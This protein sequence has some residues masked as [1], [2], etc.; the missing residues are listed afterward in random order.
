MTGSSTSPKGSNNAQIASSRHLTSSAV[1]LLP[2][3]LGLATAAAAVA[4]AAEAATSIGVTAVLTGNDMT[5]NQ[6]QQHLYKPVSKNINS[7]NATT[8]PSISA[9]EIN[10]E[11]DSEEDDD[12]DEDDEM[13]E[14]DNTSTTVPSITLSTST[15]G[16][17]HLHQHQHQQQ[18]QQQLQTQIHQQ[19]AQQLLEPPI[20]QQ[21]LQLSDTSAHTTD[22][23]PPSASANANADVNTASTEA[24]ALILPD[25]A[26]LDTNE[27]N[28]DNTD[29][30]DTDNMN[31][32]PSIPDDGDIT[33]ELQALAEQQDDLP[34][35]KKVCP[36]G[37]E[38][39]DKE[40]LHTVL[41][42]LI[43][44]NP[45]LGEVT[46][47]GRI[48]F[49]KDQIVD[50][51]V[52]YSLFLSGRDDPGDHNKASL[53][54]TLSQ[55]FLQPSKGRVTM[56]EIPMLVSRKDAVVPSKKTGIIPRP[57]NRSSLFD[58][59][60]DGQYLPVNS[61]R[62]EGLPPLNPPVHQTPARNDRKSLS[63]GSSAAESPDM[64]GV[65]AGTASQKKRKERERDEA[66][67]A[68]DPVFKVVSIRC[69][70]L[71][72]LLTPTLGS[73]KTQAASTSAASSSSANTSSSAAA[74]L[75]LASATE[76]REM[77]VSSTASGGLEGSGS[78]AGLLSYL[79]DRDVMY[80]RE[81]EQAEERHREQ[82]REIEARHADELARTVEVFKRNEALQKASVTRL[83]RDLA[84]A[85][86][87]VGL[88]T[89]GVAP[90]QWIGVDGGEETV[91]GTTTSSA[92]G[93]PKIA[94]AIQPNT[95]NE[96][97]AFA[98]VI[99]ER[100]MAIRLVEDTKV[101]MEAA[102]SRV[103]DCVAARRKLEEVVRRLE[104]ERD[105]AVLAKEALR[106]CAARWQKEVKFLRGKIASSSG[107]SVVVAGRIGDGS[108][109]SGAGAG[110][111]SM[112]FEYHGK[113]TDD[114]SA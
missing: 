24:S 8:K 1:P 2:T 69:L 97:D 99:A 88:M 72:A 31:D 64:E 15:S 98:S 27:N 19:Q 35:A 7:I 70:L 58:I 49:T 48:S 42:T 94:W 81:R 56:K 47:D 101:A 40:K 38:D 84:E 66:S 23:L 21:Q 93:T 105:E 112:R 12:E 28:N 3:G 4:A 110:G 9:T 76:S 32:D 86:A 111:S 67:S 10:E 45:E 52:T 60:E 114:G 29:E 55:H 62:P 36:C 34:P 75:S 95:K 61:T 108:V 13:M 5:N 22:S 50:G 82:M 39:V 106:E 87:N 41:Y 79:K 63:A 51:V 59:G 78:D 26:K 11:V 17:Q 46:D 91:G 104:K 107:A 43:D 74:T 90:R 77:V 18:Q 44:R 25:T 100:E 57:Y 83:K 113:V 37:N 6:H 85:R 16:L 96:L 71:N 14:M 109:G 80:Q 20:Q 68:K 53:K 30:N 33:D 102:M 89:P 73:S 65:D 92:P 103:V 54:A